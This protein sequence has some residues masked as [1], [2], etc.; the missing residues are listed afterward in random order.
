M[1]MTTVWKYNI[2]IDDYQQFAMPSGA[3]PLCVQMQGS[4]AQLWALVDPDAQVET[5][6]FRL[7]GTGHQIDDTNP[8]YIGSFQMNNGVFIFHLFEI[9]PPARP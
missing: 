7:A 2:A 5:R 1:S 9:D 8:R 4:F 6:Y 3:Q